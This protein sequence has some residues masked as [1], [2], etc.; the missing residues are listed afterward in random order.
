[1][2]SV[3]LNEYSCQLRR[4]DSG[5]ETNLNATFLATTSG[6]RRLFCFLLLVEAI[7]VPKLL[8]FLTEQNYSW[9]QKNLLDSKYYI[10][11]KKIFSAKKILGQ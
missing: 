6:L 8:F 1:M 7:S 5:G 2:V 11:G 10:K 9:D 3:Y 4:L